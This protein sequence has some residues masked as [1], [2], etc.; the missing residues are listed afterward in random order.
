MFYVIGILLAHHVES[1][2][3]V[4]Y[5]ILLTAIMLL[6]SFSA[7]QYVKNKSWK[8]RWI[9]GLVLGLAI[10][11]SGIFFTNIHIGKMD[12]QLPETKEIY[13]G[14]ITKQPS[15]S[16]HSVK[17][18]IKINEIVDSASQLQKPI[19]VMAYF[20]IDSLSKSLNYGEKLL[21][22][23][24]FKKP[25]GP[26]NPG[27]FNYGAYLLRNGISAV[28][29]V[30]GNSWE[31][32]AYEPEYRIFALANNTRLKVL[33]ALKENGLGDKEFGVAAAV[34]LG[35]DEQMDPELE[36]DYVRAGAMHI[37]CVSGLHVGVVFLVLN[38]L[39]GF[40]KKGCYSNLIKTI[41]LIL[42][43]WA[44]ALLTGM[45]PSVIRASA[46]LSILIVG[47]ATRRHRDPYNNL[48][49]AAVVMLVIDPMLLYNLGFQLSY[50]AVLGILIFYKPIYNLVYVKN[51]F[52]DKVWSV[53]VVSI[54]AQLGTF[55]LAAHYFHYLPTYFWL[56]NI[57]I[58]PVSFAIVAVGL[59]FI[60]VSWMPFL[61]HVIGLILSALVYVMN[62]IVGLVKYLP[63]NGFESLY[64]PWLKVALVYGLIFALYYWLLK[65]N[66]R[67]ILPVAIIS[68]ALIIFQTIHKYQ[69]LNQSKLVVYSL[70]KNSAIDFIDGRTH[71]MLMDSSLIA[72]RSKLD[73]H[74]KNYKIEMGLDRSISW[75]VSLLN[76]RLDLFH[77]G[78]FFSFN[79]FDFIVM[80]GNKKYFPS[81]TK[82]NV[83]AIL[84]QGKKSFKLADIR[85]C[86][87]FE[88]LVVDGS[89]PYWKKRKIIKDSGAHGIQVYDVSESGAFIRDF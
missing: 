71:L 48:A 65:R 87:N 27:E 73:Y 16:E 5:S 23:A 84:I 22:A 9:N 85:Q 38:F 35:Y 89:V 62:F 77:D 50:C 58:M 39:L 17:T 42:F 75:S 10:G 43:I 56:T 51:K 78:E 57:P 45:S 14:V 64:F 25:S 26:K 44:Y 24:A 1:I 4:P 47:N 70:N 67:F 21:V 63:G 2:R 74:L 54:A 8:Y 28:G 60:I 30:Q 53:M 59:F 81:K 49:I 82:I 88:L 79:G 40:L 33:K 61:P 13:I 55:P 34:L 83:D 52:L 86:V 19:R 66:L 46:M 41:L 3:T 11:L 6:L 18:V 76:E 69:V 32:L 12:V 37:L 80:N 29:Y 20:A 68:L 15:L 7:Y 72:D 31:K 36:Q